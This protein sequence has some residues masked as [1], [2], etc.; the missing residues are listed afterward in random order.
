LLVTS[1]KLHAI[2]YT[3]GGAKL[4]GTSNSV[5]FLQW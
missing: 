1:S 4:N 5:G 2:G 3:N